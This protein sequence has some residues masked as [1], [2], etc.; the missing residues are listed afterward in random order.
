M[1]LPHHWDLPETIKQRFGQKSPGKQRAMEADGHL[2]LVLHQAPHPSQKTRKTI[3]Y[4]RKPTGEWLSSNQKSPLL[5]QQKDAGLKQ[6][7]NHLQEY[8]EIET[9]FSQQYQNAKNAQDYFQILQHITPLHRAIQNL[10]ATLQT[11]R[12]EIPSDQDLIDLRDFA[13]E[14]ERNLDLLYS[15][16]KNALD[17][18]L[19]EKAEEQ[20]RLSL[21]SLHSSDRLN[22]LMAIFLPLTALT[23]VFG[24]NL[25]SGLENSPILIFWLI[26]GGGIYLGFLIR[27]WVFQKSRI[28]KQESEIENIK[29]KNKNK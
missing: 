9:E 23:S 27:G 10:H 4:W 13:Y 8:S 19:A 21:E 3:F 18:Y 7:I 17:F 22:I 16:T 5:S 14:L 2:L 6:L 26:F 1:Q 24:M 20:T 11:A 25:P 15:D 12:E 28:R 29:Y